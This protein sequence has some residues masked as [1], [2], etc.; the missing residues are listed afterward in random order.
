MKRNIS[1]YK[2]MTLYF[3]ALALAGCGKTITQERPTVVKVPI[4]ASCV[5][6]RPIPVPTMQER[7]PDAVWNEMDIRQKVAELGKQ[8]LYEQIYG[9]RLAAATG[10]C[11]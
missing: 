7:V 2:P 8:L 9:R 10:G 11:E 3:L 5:G 1:W 6:V 4:S